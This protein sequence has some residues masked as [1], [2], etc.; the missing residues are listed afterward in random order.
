MD[1]SLTP[2]KVSRKEVN[3][4]VIVSDYS[5]P[6]KMIWLHQWRVHESKSSVRGPPIFSGMDLSLYSC[7][8]QPI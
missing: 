6:L 4:I 1:V 3:R 8:E 7:Q 5:T 2:G